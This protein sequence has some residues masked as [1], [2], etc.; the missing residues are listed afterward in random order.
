MKKLSLA[1]VP[2]FLGQVGAVMDLFAPIR[3]SGATNWGV[4]DKDRKADLNTLKSV[5]SPK[6]VFFPQ[7]QTMYTV[8]KDEEGFS[9]DPMKLTDQPFCVFGIRPCDV[10]ALE[11][12]DQV[13]LAD[14]VDTF[15]KARR[16]N[17]ILVS[18]ACHR[19]AQTC[20]C[21]V[22]GTDASECEGADVAMW[23]IGEDLFMEGCTQK[24]HAFLEQFAD[25]LQDTEDTAAVEAEKESIRAIT[26]KLPYA[27]LS[28]EG[29]GAGMTDEKF[30]DPNWQ[31]L[32][33]ACL[34]CGTCT[35]VCPTCQCYDIKDYD[36]GHGIQRYR[37]WD[38]CMYSDFTLMAAANNR[39]TQMQRY[40]QRF[41]HKLVYFPTNNNGMYMCVGC[42]RCVDRCPQALNIVKVIKTMDPGR[43]EEKA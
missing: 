16:E 36:T 7:C 17:A 39:T 28:L 43:K 25:L 3:M 4:W 41:M 5:K 11:V 20:F 12:M 18:L 19:P 35:F 6:D 31:Q 9:I 23:M 29:W 24:G 1:D 38:S 10:K 42:G 32:S 14:P 26:K 8:H 15:Y 33:D 30:D 13:F 40:R 22:F 34:A 2:K 37:C 27:G 21:S